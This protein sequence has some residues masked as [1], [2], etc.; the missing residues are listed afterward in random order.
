[1]KIFFCSKYASFRSGG[2]AGTGSDNEVS[3]VAD[4]LPAH[5]RI[6]MQ[7]V[8]KVFKRYLPRRRKF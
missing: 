8:L 4:T 3:N 1:M 6:N 7:N 5:V 2:G